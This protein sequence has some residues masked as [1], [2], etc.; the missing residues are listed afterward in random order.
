MA[1]RVRGVAPFRPLDC[2]ETEDAFIDQLHKLNNQVSLLL[3]MKPPVFT[4]HWQ[5]SPSL[6]SSLVLLVLTFLHYAPTALPQACDEWKREYV[7]ILEGELL[8]RVLKLTERILA[9]SPA[10]LLRSTDFI[11]WTKTT[12]K[13]LETQ[14]DLLFRL[15]K[16]LF[17]VG[18]LVR[19]QM[20]A[21]IPKIQREEIVGK[22]LACF[23]IL[24][25]AAYLDAQEIGVKS[26]ASILS[27]LGR[28]CDLGIAAKGLKYLSRLP[29]WQNVDLPALTAAMIQKGPENCLIIPDL[30][31]SAEAVEM[32]GFAEDLQR[33]T[34]NEAS[35]Q[36]LLHALP[37]LTLQDARRLLKKYDGS[38]ASAIDAE[39][40]RFKKNEFVELLDD[41]SFVKSNKEYLLT[42]PA[43]EVYEDE[44]V[45][46]F[47]DAGQT[48]TDPDIATRKVHFTSL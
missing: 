39:G 34:R 32:V 24:L 11:F 18:V 7:G 38:V 28:E 46:T 10:P 2:F 36:A 3:R 41:K 9:T 8:C 26:M 42:A 5:K 22:D 44:Y 30:I 37:K 29:V 25:S 35:I 20:V 13:F 45:D 40:P 19:K 12:Q 15:L 4:E 21:I 17:K 31:F 6:Q 1:S 14:D 48:T 33:E 23:C 47:D 16:T 27:L 43:E